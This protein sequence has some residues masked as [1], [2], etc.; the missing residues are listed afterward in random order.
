MTAL[1]QDRAEAGRAL[2]NELQGVVSDRDVLVLALPRGGVP[3]A[4]EVAEAFDA[5]LD[6]LLVR[7]LGVPGC[8][9]LAMGA[10]AL[11]GTDVVRVLNPNVVDALEL[12]KDVI[13]RVA[14]QET[15]ELHRRA[16]RYRGD[17]RAPRL[18]GRSI[19][20]VD[21][22]LATGATMR[23]AALALQQ[24]NAERVVIAVPV[25]P[26]TTVR[27][28]RSDADDI[29]CVATPDPFWAV[30][31]WYGDF[32]QVEDEEVRA[33]LEQRRARQQQGPGAGVGAGAPASPQE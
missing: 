26:P 28:L 14:A 10:I 7:K 9:E 25:A 12:Q 3:V 13:D 20:V 21:D 5:E 16:R 32:R 1:F 2:V 18:K 31:A 6:V 4:Y 29:V 30:G 17:A 33:L 23:S 8:E 15:E 11:G 22:G 19:I 24:V 27:A